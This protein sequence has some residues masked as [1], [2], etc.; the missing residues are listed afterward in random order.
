MNEKEVYHTYA[1]KGSVVTLVFLT[2]DGKTQIFQWM[3]QRTK[4]CIVYANAA[5]D[6]CDRVSLCGPYGICSI[7]QHPPCGCMQGFE[8]RNLEE[9]EVSDW[10]SGC[11]RKKPLHW[12]WGSLFEN[13]GSEGYASLDIRN[14]GGGSLL[15]L[16]ELLDTREYDVNQVST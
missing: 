16:D 3:Y 5:V 10:V 15:W 8:S 12:E 13:C 2:W 6:S 7:N 14:G 9:W 11:I 4:E 1:L